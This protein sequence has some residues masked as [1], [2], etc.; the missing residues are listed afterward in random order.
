MSQAG[1]MFLLVMCLLVF[2]RSTPVLGWMRV[3][4]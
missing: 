3:G 2:L 1:K 4:G